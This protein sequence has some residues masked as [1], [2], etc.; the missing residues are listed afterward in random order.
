MCVNVWVLVFECWCMYLC[1]YVYIIKGLVIK[2]HQLRLQKN[3]YKCL[4]LCKYQQN[5]TKTINE[6]KK[7][8]Q[9]QT[10]YSQ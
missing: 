2:N 9:K 7:Q 4:V 6:T 5:K 10:K 1:I 8:T 3:N